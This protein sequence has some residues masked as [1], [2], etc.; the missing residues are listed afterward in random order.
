MKI[1]I[2][3]GCHRAASGT[4]SLGPSGAPQPCQHSGGTAF[5]ARHR[6]ET[7]AVGWQLQK[8][9]AR[10]SHTAHRSPCL[11]HC[12]SLSGVPANPPVMVVSSHSFEAVA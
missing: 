6:Q 11:T 1:H 9:A 3:P 4:G 8:V 5:T 12:A 10:A 2:I 7:A